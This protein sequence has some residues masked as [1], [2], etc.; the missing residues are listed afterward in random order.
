LLVARGLKWGRDPISVPAGLATCVITLLL[1]LESFDATPNVKR[2]LQARRF[3]IQEII[4]K[5]DRT[6]DCEQ[7]LNSRNGS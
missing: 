6:L 4:P 2:A 1:I 7:V 3:G 5:I